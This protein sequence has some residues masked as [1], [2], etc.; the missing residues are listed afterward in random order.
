MRNLKKR[1]QVKIAYWIMMMSDGDKF[2]LIQVLIQGR[3]YCTMPLQDS[4]MRQRKERKIGHCSE[5]FTMKV[6]DM[7]HVW[8]L[9]VPSREY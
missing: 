1:K 4:L 8:M 6:E 2:L 9:Q 7:L 5:G 3:N